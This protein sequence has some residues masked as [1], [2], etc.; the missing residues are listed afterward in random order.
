[1]TQEMTA[2]Q[3]GTFIF[4][5]EDKG[6]SDSWPC[7]SL[8]LTM[9]L[10]ALTSATVVVGCGY[11]LGNI[12]N[13][14]TDHSAE[15]L[16]K[17]VV[18][19]V[20]EG[21]S[22]VNCWIVER[23]SDDEEYLVFA[24]VVVG[25]SLVYKAGT[26]TN[27]AVRFECL[28]KACYLY[29]VPMGL[30]RYLVGSYI[31]TAMTGWETNPITQYGVL[32]SRT[33]DIAAL[34]TNLAPKISGPA[35]I[36]TRIS[37][38]VDGIIAVSGGQDTVS[39][40]PDTLDIMHIR[41]YIACPYTINKELY[42]KRRPLNAYQQARTSSPTYEA[43][44]HTDDKSV[45]AVDGDFNKEIGMRLLALLQRSSVLEAIVAIVTSD[46]YMMALSPR[47]GGG[48]ILQPS[49][50]W[51]GDVK[52]VLNFSKIKSINST[53]SPLKHVA[54]P[55]VFVVN[56][57]AAIPMDG[58]IMP[59]LDTTGLPVALTGIY[60]KH[61]EVMEMR[62][63]VLSG[64]KTDMPSIIPSIM[65][66]YRAYS[67]PGWLN[68]AFIGNLTTPDQSTSEQQ[69]PANNVRIPDLYQ[70]NKEDRPVKENASYDLNDGR[71]IADKIAKALFAFIHGRT[72][73][74]E[75]EVLPNLRFG[76]GEPDMSTALEN[77]IGEVIDILP[78]SS[79]DKELM[80]KTDNLLAIRGMVSE[81]S[82]SYDSGTASSCSYSI[83]LSRVRPVKD[84]EESI[85]CPLYAPTNETK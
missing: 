36:I 40:N 53:V 3:V 12:E 51:A 65:F 69:A 64:K 31:M 71:K 37:Y 82:F 29:A 6:V 60:T 85:V 19:N 47:L 76:Y 26:V 13:D 54:D 63:A 44:Q 45:N 79:M 52:R 7:T 15:L 2:D 17:R 68:D 66:K 34:C 16:M 28:D 22:M 1:M 4:Y 49:K 77:L 81:V 8:K 72:S 56:Y 80:K 11:A 42:T 23:F 18:D 32:Y 84:R 75:I 83:K 38:I 24:G 25:A 9:G 59:K 33:V 10:N 70:T 35:D 30:T 21:S 39:V 43:Y 46:S 55:D 62:D 50:A 67:A 58:A 48:M 41:D 73:T 20:E 27:R 5:A 78:D 14:K 61:K 57:S 74:A